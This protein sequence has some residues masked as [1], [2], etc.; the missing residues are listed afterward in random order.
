[1]RDCARAVLAAA[2][3]ALI[4]C[5]CAR[6][7][8]TAPIRDGGT[9][10]DVVVQHLGKAIPG[11]KDHP[12]DDEDKI[13]PRPIVLWRGS[14]PAAAF[15]YR[16]RWN[17]IESAGEQRIG[18]LD[19]GPGHGWFSREHGPF[20]LVFAARPSENERAQ[21]PTNAFDTANMVTADVNG[22]GVDELLLPR[23]NGAIGVYGVDKVLFEQWAPTAP[24]GTRYHAELT[25]TAKLPGR[26]VVFFL[27]ALEKGPKADEAALGKAER[28]ALY[29]VDQKGIARVP[30][31]PVGVHVGTILAVGALNRPGSLDLDEILVL[32]DD[33]GTPGKTFLSRHR[34]DGSAIEAPKEA[35]V[36][37]PIMGAYFLFSPGTPQAI[38]AG[39]QNKHLYFIRPEKAS[40]WIAQ[41][42]LNPLASS[43]YDIKIH[44][45]VDPGSD[46]KVT[47]AVR[48]RG[49]AGLA[50]AAL[51]A[52]N[53][54]G[55]SFRPDPAR[56]GWQT[57]S[58]RGPYLQVSTPTAQHEFRGLLPQPGADILLAVYSRE[59]QLKR[60]SDEEVMSAADRFMRPAVVAQARKDNLEFGVEALKDVPNCSKE[61]RIKRGVTE[62]ITSIEQWKRLLPDSYS[63][64]LAFA[65]RGFIVDLRV[66]LES[67][68]KRP[69]DPEKFVNV[70][71]YKAWLGGLKLGPE[72]VFDV[73]RRG[74]VAARFPVAGFLPRDF[75]YDFRAGSAGVSIVLPLDVTP[76]VGPTKQPPGFYLVELHR[77][78]F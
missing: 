42:D 14:T 63:D 74:E 8:A 44:H 71:E 39:G 3:T 75:N 40:N 60:L 12:P 17:A 10:D 4:L 23:D 61:E 32:F 70:E 19:E 6:C 31:A 2:L 11:R 21:G 26:D 46:P 58:A 73:I 67:G 69:I 62:E 29:R 53:G 52:I 27:L 77:K 20:P 25:Y 7:R 33:G 35:Y 65:M 45:A 64:V 15:Y 38:L 51:Y 50:R 36:P 68:A 55:K 34:S 48:L 24:P 78:I 49:D 18:R 66:D 59:A 54:E 30:L 13:D 28:Y 22:D 16:D 43:P 1:V 57:L 47:V 5:G 56:E 76:S 37:T 41:V 9:M 72:T